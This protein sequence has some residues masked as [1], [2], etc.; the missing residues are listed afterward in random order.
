MDQISGL[1]SVP[2]RLERILRREN[3]P[4]RSLN[5]SLPNR[6]LVFPPRERR[7]FYPSLSITGFAFTTA[8]YFLRHQI[9]KSETPISGFAIIVVSIWIVGGRIIAVLASSGYKRLDCT[10]RRRNV[11]VQSCVKSC[12]AEQESPNKIARQSHD[13]SRPTA[14]AF[15]FKGPLAIDAVELVT[16]LA[17]LSGMIKKFILCYRQR[18]YA[19][20]IFGLV[21]NAY[22]AWFISTIVTVY[23]QTCP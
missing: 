8:L 14:D 19:L 5:G 23:P 16:R 3:R 2:V 10:L 21:L 15:T 11:P 20:S 4:T 9:V 17:C 13:R 1:S 22:L 12:P 7:I 18:T 6:S